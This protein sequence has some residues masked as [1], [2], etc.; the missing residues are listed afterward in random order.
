MNSKSQTRLFYGMLIGIIIISLVFLIPIS[1]SDEIKPKD[2]IVL[3]KG[4]PLDNNGDLKYGKGWIIINS[5]GDNFTVQITDK[6]KL[7]T[8]IC[9][10]PVNDS[11]ILDASKDLYDDKNKSIAKLPKST[12]DGKTEYCYDTKGEKYL[13]FNPTVIYQ[14]LNLVQ[15]DYTFG[16]TNFTLIKNPSLIID[17]ITVYMKDGAWK[18]SAIDNSI[19]E[20]QLANYSYIINSTSELVVSSGS[21]GLRE[22]SINY[23]IIYN[24]YPN[25]IDELREVYDF[26]DICNNNYSNCIV[27]SYD[28]YNIKIDFTSTKYIDP[29]IT[30]VSGCATLGTAGAYYQLNTSV[31][32]N[33]LTTDCMIINN[34]NITFDGNGYFISSNKNFTGI[35]SNQ[36]NITIIN[37]NITMGTGNNTNSIGIELAAGGN[38]SYIINNTI[39]GNNAYYGIYALARFNVF[40]NNTMTTNCVNCRAFFMSTGSAD[41]NI[42]NNSFYSK[43]NNGLFLS[44][45]NR[46]I[47]KNNKVYSTSS[48]ALYLSQ[49]D[50]NTLMYNTVQSNSSYGIVLFASSNNLLNYNNGTSNNTLDGID[51][52]GGNN[53]QYYNNIGRGT[54]RYGIFIFGSNNNT[55]ENNT[56]ISNTSYG[57]YIAHSNNNTLR[58][59]LA[60][61]NTASGIVLN[62]ITGTNLFNNT[63]TSNTSIVLYLL[64]SRNNNIYNHT[65]IGY[66]GG[67]QG[68]LLQSSN[69][70][71][72]KDCVNITSISTDVSLTSNSVNLT[73]LNCSYVTESLDA[74]SNLTRKWYYRA[75]SNNTENQN[76]VSNVTAYNS[77]GQ[78]QFSILTNSTGWTNITE[79]IDYVNL[80]GTINYYSPYTINATNSSQIIP[81]SVNT[82]NASLGNDLN[83]WF[84]FDNSYPIFFLNKTSPINNTQ[85]NIGTIYLFNISINNTNA[86]TGIEFNGINYSLNNISESFYYNTI[87]LSAGTVSYYY[88]SYSANKNHMFNKSVTYFYT[89]AKNSSLNLGLTATTPIIYPNPTDFTGS[90]CPDQLT[91]SLNISN[92]VYGAGTVSGNYSTPGNANY[93][94]NS[95]IFTVTINKNSSTCDI[96]FN[97]TS[98]QSYPFKFTSYGDCTTNFYLTRNGTF[99]NNNSEQDL[100]AGTYNFTV[101]RNDTQNY[102]VIA[103]NKTFTID[104]N[105]TYNLTLFVT[106]PITYGTPTTVTNTSCPLQINCSLYR[107]NTGLISSPDNSVLSA[108]FYNYTFNTSGNANYSSKSISLLLQINK[109]TPVIYT[110]LNNLR[111]NLSTY[112][113]T[114]VTVN[115]T[116]ISGESN[117]LLY[118]NGTLINNGTQLKNITTYE[119]GTYNITT[120]YLETE[121]YTSAFETWWIFV[122]N[123][124]GQV[125]SG[126]GGGGMPSVKQNLTASIVIPE[127]WKFNKINKVQVYP[128]LDPDSIYFEFFNLSGVYI[129]QLTMVKVDDYYSKEFQAYS[130]DNIEKASTIVLKTTI[131][132]GSLTYED[133]KTIQITKMTFLENTLDMF[134]TR[135]TGNMFLNYSLFAVILMLMFFVIPILI[136][137]IRKKSNK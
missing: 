117:I 63:A 57:L 43:D 34:Q 98:S 110:Y 21:D 134:N 125:D 116:R 122:T 84:I 15:Y 65:S 109:A 73:A 35:Y 6:D 47:L 74:G 30:N 24:Y 131:T 112:N 77:S 126:G 29:T 66:L 71:Y 99:I 41:C 70:T 42:T 59:N 113:Q 51:A 17:N 40:E 75:Y 55:L 85:Y 90:G 115:G 135:L 9:F 100:S 106:T 18:I 104:Q 118:N 23:P 1:S 19:N 22:D 67:S 7:L 87:N 52:N 3:D 8:T 16:E 107:N 88:W 38:Y 133:Y 94:S 97:A 91:C 114:N 82:F 39:N 136:Y 27:T 60:V 37:N 129:N 46:N 95:T 48:F 105:N 76:V 128:S 80:G 124:T 28:K 10:I 101:F 20:T 96:Y 86:S 132:K 2:I 14:E 50:N 58:N 78:F 108:G 61:S 127:D 53:N 4:L 137:L 68:V 12:K 123:F 31:T 121:N 92:G 79:I 54:S 81:Y 32:N 13:K 103:N 89:V 36:K 56:A 102:S 62:N 111:A 64:S 83:N 72:L 11:V 69:N 130:Q 5:S 119:A 93:T 120:I 45:S 33:T 26:K 44:Q 25:G 49:S